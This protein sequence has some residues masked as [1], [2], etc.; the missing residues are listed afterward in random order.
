MDTIHL[1]STDIPKKQTEIP[2]KC[3][4][5]S[6]IGDLHISNNVK[7]IGAQAF[8][9]CDELDLATLGKNVTTVKTEAFLDC[10]ELKSIKIPKS[11][12]TIGTRAFGF[13]SDWDCDD[14]GIEIPAF[15]HVDMTITGYK[16]SAAEKYAKKNGLKFKAIK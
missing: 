5:N 7:T 13:Y 3:F 1:L 16:G 2:E 15:S 10:K 12:K 4:F 6:R 11:V 14:N 9:K 8:A